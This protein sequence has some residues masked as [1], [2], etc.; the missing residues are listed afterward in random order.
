MV[1]VDRLAQLADHLGSHRVDADEQPLQQLAVGQRVP[2]RVSLDAVVTAD[3]HHRRLLLGARDGIPRHPERR[4]E[5][6][7]VAPRL[8][9]G[10]AH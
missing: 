7:D 3:D 9:R 10:D 6:E 8:D 1:E 2:A 4:L 5:R